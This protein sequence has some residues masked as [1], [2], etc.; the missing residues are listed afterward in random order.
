MAKKI[1]QGS[2]FELKDE[3]I[4]QYIAIPPDILYEDWMER[5]DKKIGLDD[6]TVMCAPFLALIRKYRMFSLDSKRREVEPEIFR[7][8]MSAKR[9]TKLMYQQFLAMFLDP[10]NFKFYFNTLPANAK[11]LWKAVMR[12]QA[13]TFAEANK[14]AGNKVVSTSGGW[15]SVATLSPLYVGWFKTIRG[16]V[17]HSASYNDRYNV[18]CPRW[19]LVAHLVSVVFAD[20]MADR[21]G[22]DA[23]PEKEGLITFNA[24]EKIFSELPAIVALREGQ[25]FEQKSNTLLTAGC[26]RQ[27]AK[28]L[29]MPEFFPES[30][31]KNLKIMRANMVLNAVCN[32]ILPGRKMKPSDPELLKSI[33]TVL[34][35]AEGF[36]LAVLLPDLKGVRPTIFYDNDID[37]VV[38]CFFFSLCFP[39]NERWRS[40]DTVVLETMNNADCRNFR[41]FDDYYYQRFTLENKY[42]AKYVFT[43]NLMEQVTL[44]LLRGFAFLLAAFGLVEIA[45]RAPQPGEASPYDGL[46]YVRATD[47]G[48]FCVGKIKEYKP[49]GITEKRLFEADADAL[50]VKSLAD[51]NPLLPI[52]AD[53][54]DPITQR[55]YKI[56]YA[57]FLR[58]CSDAA[59]VQTR[60]KQFKKYICPAPS[61]V[62][63]TFFSEVRSRFKP[64]E[65]VPVKYILTK[66]P[67]ENK[68]L[69]R[70]LLTDPVIR[71]YTVKAEGFLL[72]IEE[73]HMKQVSER[74]K[75]YGYVL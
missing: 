45:Y 64:F 19:S 26:L 73:D 51:D 37:N 12:R 29:Q 72:L 36:L 59:D 46:Q 11:A 16:N 71:K 50:I 15:Y 40:F 6:L 75:T 9:K 61:A 31:D 34:E 35:S 8:I 39:D 28:L 25:K 2:L 63:K 7:T 44:P 54:A 3:R 67:K 14:I 69:Q 4:A 10:F 49:K 52:L 41:L 55:L 18:L 13:L 65:S 22:Y 70:I 1:M 24:E 68:E 74:L 5:I 66:I 62:W 33:F 27:T 21:E 58:S 43:N 23:L 56:S 60:I 17:S 30:E 42:S 38:D 20:E 53:M 48:R 47:L 32:V 57:S